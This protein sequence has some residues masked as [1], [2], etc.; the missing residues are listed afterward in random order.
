M[1][2]LVARNKEQVPGIGIPIVGTLPSE[3]SPTK[4]VYGLVYDN[5]T[6]KIGSATL[7]TDGTI[8]VIP[9]EAVPYNGGTGDIIHY[10][11][12]I[13]FPSYCVQ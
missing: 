1:T 7:K 9:W 5:T 3:F 12:S 2:I 11:A 8:N 4:T 6:R 13:I 10:N